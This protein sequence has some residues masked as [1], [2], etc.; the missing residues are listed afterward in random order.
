MSD[1]TSLLEQT[2]L[3]AIDMWRVDEANAVFST[4]IG[5]EDQEELPSPGKD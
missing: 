3:L 5:Q 1:F 4:P 2:E